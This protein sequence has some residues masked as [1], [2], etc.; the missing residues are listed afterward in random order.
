MI[1]RNSW[2]FGNHAALY[3]SSGWGDEP[4]IYDPAGSYADNNGGGSG[5]MVVGE[6]AANIIAFASHH[7][8]LGD[9]TVAICKDT[10][11]EE[12]KDFAAKA[13]EQGGA[14]GG[15]CSRFVSD[16]IAGSKPF[17]NVKPGTWFP[18]NLAD[19]AR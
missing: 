12:E 16:V 5:Q 8:K 4:F 18:G 13:E 14:M 17:P 6:K 3:G 2:K 7:S 19:D 15:F 9:T 10:T 1:T 11:L